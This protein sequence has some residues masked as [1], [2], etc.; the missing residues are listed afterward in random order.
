VLSTLPAGVTTSL[1]AEA[2]VDPVTRRAAASL[3]YRGALLVYLVVPRRPYS[4]FD[5]HYFPELRVPM[6]RVS[7][8]ANY[9]SAAADPPDHTVLCA[10]LPASPSE[11]WWSLDDDA[12]GRLDA[13]ALVAE[14]LPDPT[15]VDVAV[16]RV[17]HVYPVYRLDHAAHQQ[18]LEAWAERRG[19]LVLFGRQPLFA[20]DNTHH[21]LAMARAVAS[22]LGL[23]G[24]FDRERWSALRDGFRDHVVED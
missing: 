17:E 3:S 5:A 11:E 2:D 9:R 10:E 13:T 23:G 18:A 6:A 1:Y 7:E 4:P 16:R 20:H 8:P 24:A 12:L 14:G 21:A 22:C 19:E 15:P